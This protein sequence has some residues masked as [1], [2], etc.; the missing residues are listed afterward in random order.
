[1]ETLEQWERRNGSAG[2]Y[3]DFFEAC[4]HCLA[5]H[6]PAPSVTSDYDKSVIFNAIRKGE[7]ADE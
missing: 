4:F 7:G 3:R 1:V 5:G 2:E 6:Y